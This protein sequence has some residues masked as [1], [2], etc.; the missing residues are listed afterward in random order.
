MLRRINDKKAKNIL[1]I[2][3]ETKENNAKTSIANKIILQK[4]V[5][6]ILTFVPIMNII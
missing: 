1:K 5:P 6:Y 4:N 3:I 2:V